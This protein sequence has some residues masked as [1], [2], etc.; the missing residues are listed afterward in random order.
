MD[1]A[2]RYT[3]ALDLQELPS[4]RVILERTN[5][6]ADPHEAEAAGVRLIMPTAEMLAELRLS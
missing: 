1:F 2:Q 5:A 4:A 3:A 6:F